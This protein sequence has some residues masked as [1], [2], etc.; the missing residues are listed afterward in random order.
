M[1]HAF[2]ADMGGFLLESPGSELFPI[3]AEQLFQLVK[4]GYVSY[5]DIE[6]EDI[7]DKSK[8]GSLSRIVA[9][10][11]ASWFLINCVTRAAQNIFITTLEITT[12]S[13][14][15]IFFFTS[16]CWHYKS[17]DVSRAVIL[18]TNTPI[19]TIRS[20]FHPRPQE[21]WHRTPLDFL[22]RDEWLCS[23]LWRYYIQ[24]LHYLHI[25]IFARPST[26]LYDY[27]PSDTFLRLDTLAEVIF[28]PCMLSFAS[29]FMCAWNFEFPTST[30][31]LI[32]R[33]ATVYQTF[34][35]SVGAL[36]CWYAN[37]FILPK[38]LPVSEKPPNGYFH[39]LAWK[40][41]NIYEDRDPDLI[42]PLR[43]LI[44]NAFLCLLYSASR[45]FILLE[46]FIGLRSLPESA[47]QT[48]NWSKYVPH[49]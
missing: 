26:K 22:S 29:M 33:A 10:V 38:R 14:I 19:A 25:P 23:C 32:W 42:V 5:P 4:A 20:K 39:W 18:Q 37:A 44:P 7:K 48:V 9:S 34:F 30:E 41:R 15:V 17:Q 12:L 6:M 1:V 43:V 11:Q 3:D 27:I 24:I 16:F 45:V 35:G 49:W 2:F 28:V 36:I 13:F 46:D 47:F 31:R 21:N 8:S 40:M